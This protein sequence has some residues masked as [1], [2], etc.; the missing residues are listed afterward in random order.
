MRDQSIRTL[1]HGVNH[2]KSLVNLLSNFCAS[3]NDLTTDENEE[4]NLRLDHAVDETREQFR[5]IGTEVVMARGQTLET[6]GKLDVAGAD[7]VLD[8]EIRELRIEPKLLNDPGIFARCKLRV[9]LGLGTSN[10]HLARCKDES[11]SL[12]FPDSHN[13][14]G[15]TLSE[16]AEARTSFDTGTLP[17]DCIQ[18]FVRVRR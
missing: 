7:N 9:I 6:N 8:L 17:L 10:N 11:C 12:G 4:H 16:L 5:F 18:H 3:E 14:G 1:K 2:F 13:H 15:K